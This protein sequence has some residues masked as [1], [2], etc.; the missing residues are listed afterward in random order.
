MKT[1]FTLL[2]SGFLGTHF[3]AA[4][5]TNAP[6]KIPS[7][8]N[9][10]LYLL[11]GQSNM[12][13]RGEIGEQD[14]TPHPRVYVFTTN[15]TWELA[16][17][18]IT[19]D[20]LKGLGA[21]PGLAFGKAMA[22]KNPGVVIGLVPCAVGGTP[23]SRWS[24]DGDLYSNAVVRAKAAMREGTLKGILW[25]QGENDSLQQSTAETYE[26]RLVK[27][28]GD[29]RSELDSPELPF[30]LG[31]IGEFLYTRKDPTKTPFARIINDA[32]T[33]I[34]NKVPRTACVKSAGLHHK[35]DEVHF[36]AASQHELGR[37]Y[38]DEMLRLLK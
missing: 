25:H 7:K 30:V 29:V 34:P 23:L 33:D 4:E 16:V 37:R 6:V 18:P 10:H 8:E 28:I 35:G 38:A 11:M 14:K 22:E 15:K 26:P 32:L 24:K 9:F 21:G 3:L 20:R 5:S 13:G 31:E 1:I 2:L 36:D 27:M 19:R 17:E 12:A